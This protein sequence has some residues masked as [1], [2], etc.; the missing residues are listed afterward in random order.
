MQTKKVKRL[1]RQK[2]EIIK[3]LPHLT[4]ILRGTFIECYLECIRPNCKC[5][6]DKKYRHGPYYR[7]SYGKGKQMH[8]IYIPLNMKREVEK[9][10]DNYNKLW[11]GIEDISALNIKII[12][13]LSR[14]E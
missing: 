9:W 1:E 4:K 7:V 14:R 8:H 13:R 6:K 3:Q 5:H 10:T 12:R 11:Q 2:Q